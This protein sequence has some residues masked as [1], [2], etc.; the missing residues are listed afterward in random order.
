[1]SLTLEFRWIVYLV[2][3]IFCLIFLFLSNTIFLP[4]YQTFYDP[5]PNYI[6]SVY[7]HGILQPLLNSNGRCHLKEQ[8][9]YTQIY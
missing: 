1:M 9:T 2:A 6:Y 5:H 8:T 4:S 7:T 3:H